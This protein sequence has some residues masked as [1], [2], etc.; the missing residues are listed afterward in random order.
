M[1][2]WDYLEQETFPRCDGL[3][4]DVKRLFR[5]EQLRTF[6]CY[7]WTTYSCSQRHYS[8]KSLGGTARSNDL[9]RPGGTNSCEW[10]NGR[11]DGEKL[12]CI[13]IYDILGSWRNPSNPPELRVQKEKRNNNVNPLPVTTVLPK[14]KISQLFHKGLKKKGGVDNISLCETS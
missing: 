8:P 13:H 11:W 14:V 2:N 4:A 1:Q 5:Q 9:R 7:L 12:A 6:T 10:G 3:A